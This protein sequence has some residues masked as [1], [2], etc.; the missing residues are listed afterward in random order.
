[1]SSTS[2]VKSKKASPGPIILES[3]WT[4]W[5]PKSENY[6]SSIVEI[7]KVPLAY[8]IKKNDL[9]YKVGAD[10]DFVEEKIARTPLSGVVFE[11]DRSIVQQYLVFFTTR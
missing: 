2:D 10:A 1:M 6:F 8:V 5:E 9:P 3:K 4:E 11:S 7:N